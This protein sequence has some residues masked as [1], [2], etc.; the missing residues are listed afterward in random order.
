MVSGVNSAEIE[1]LGVMKLLSK[2]T[3]SSGSKLPFSKRGV[4]KGFTI[5]VSLNVIQGLTIVSGSRFQSTQYCA[6]GDKLISSLVMRRSSSSLG[7]SW[8]V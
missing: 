1:F 5:V 8:D 6:S 3:A 7:V 2:I 4:N